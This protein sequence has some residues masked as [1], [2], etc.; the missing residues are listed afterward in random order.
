MVNIKPVKL[1]NNTR[2]SFAKINEVLEMPNLIEIQKNSYKWFLEKGLKEVFNDSTSIT[3]YTGNLV[4]EFVDYRLDENPKYSVE[5]CKVRDVTYA[6]PLRVRARLINKETGEIKESEVFMG[7][8]PLMTESGTFVING[9]ERVIVSQLV[10]SPGVYY[11]MSYDSTGKKLFTSTVIPNRGAWLEYETDFSDIFYVRIDKNRKMPVTVLL[12]ALGLGSDA[13]ILDFFGDDERMHATIEKDITKN[14]EEAL[15]EVYRKLRPGEPLTLENSQQHLEG[16]FFDPRRYDLSRVGRYK[17]NKKLGLSNRL[18]GCTLSRPVV[19]PSTGELMAEAGELIDRARAMEMEDA[20]VTVAY[21]TVETHG[22]ETREVKIITNGM[23][24]IH[25][26]VNFDVEELGINERVSFAVLQEILEQNED[27]ESLKEA[28]RARAGDLIPN[29]IT[30]DDIFAS[31]NYVNCLA[32]DIGTTDD[33][34]HLVNLDDIEAI[35]DRYRVLDY[36][37]RK[38]ERGLSFQGD[39]RLAICHSIVIRMHGQIT[40]ESTPNAQT[41]FTVRL[42]RLKVTAE[43]TSVNDNIVPIDTNY[44]LPLPTVTQREFTFDKNRRTMFV[45]NDD[46]EIMNFVAELFAPDYNIKMP[47]GL[48]A[49]IELLKQMH[50]D[51]IIC[52]ALSEKS[53]CLSLIKFIKEGKLTSHI[54]VILLSTAQQVDERIKGV[55]SGADICLTLPFNVEYLKAVTEQLLKRNRSLKDYYK[56]SISAFE[57]S[58]GKMLHQDDK[59]FID[60]MLKIIN[61]NISNTEISTKFIA[62]E[63]GVSI[64]NLYRRLEGILNQTPTTIIKEYRLAKAEQL[65]TSTKL[66]IDEIIY[67]AGFVNR[68]TF[69]KC[70]A[71]KYGCTPK[72]YR[73]EKLSQIKQEVDE[74]PE[75]P[76]DKA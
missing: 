23:V 5:E 59:E 70:F 33:I 35:F 67:K 47:D 74:V 44:G 30:V 58:D 49:M 42:P 7:D 9:A 36:F 56:S 50:P 48:N 46:S 12:R 29:H 54:P 40:V 52:D 75:E 53:D 76:Q 19:N 2:M 25:K 10:R 18:A 31:V 37:E 26:Y 32:F 66:S 21:V 11:G 62:D 45:V 51:I 15:L 65:L 57:L 63:M 61:D 71:A 14:T 60:K 64:R 17:Y 73:K 34:D 28:I 68:G 8:F 3:D 16:L 55:E 27:E 1:G 41:T 43:N 24:D 20:G 6:A 13:E 38:S 39:L 69:F 22:G 4:L 72:V